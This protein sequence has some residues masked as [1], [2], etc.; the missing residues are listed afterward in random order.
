MVA[1][2]SGVP[3]W[4]SA[5]ARDASALELGEDALQL[6]RVRHVAL[7]LELAHHERGHAVELARRQLL[8]VVPADPDRGVGG[9]VILADLVRRA[10]QHDGALIAAEVDLDALA[11]DPRLALLHPIDE[12]V[13]GHW[14]AFRLSE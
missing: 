14:F 12:F 5:I 6:H 9:A 13:L 10:V 2:L 8:P 4:R 11:G 7:D 3:D 1:S